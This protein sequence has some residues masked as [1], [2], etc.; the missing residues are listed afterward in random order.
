MVVPTMA[1]QGGRLLNDGRALR[2]APEP[3]CS[4]PAG[5]EHLRYPDQLLAGG[6]R[7]TDHD[8][9]ATAIQLMITIATTIVVMLVITYTR[10]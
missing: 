7:R 1:T 4:S 5:P 8:T 3:A 10:R 9:M 2:A 6:L